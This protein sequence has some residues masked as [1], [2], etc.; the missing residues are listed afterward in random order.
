MSRIGEH[1]LV[2]MVHVRS[3]V[4][5]PLVLRGGVVPETAA[6]ALRVWDG[7]IVG[8]YLRGGDLRAPIDAA[9]VAEFRSA[10]R[11]T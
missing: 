11:G 8:R 10:A 4:G 6:V 5:R 2:G 3:S 1:G 7:V 9:R